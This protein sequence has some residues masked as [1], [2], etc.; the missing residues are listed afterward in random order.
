[1]GAPTG[2]PVTITLQ[3][4]TGN[5]SITITTPDENFAAAQE[6]IAVSGTIG[7]GVVGADVNGVAAT[8]TGSTFTVPAVRLAPG[9]N[10]VV[11]HGRNAAGRTATASRRGVYY[12][13]APSISISTPSANTTTGTAK[14]TVSGTY[15]NLDPATIAVGTTSA[16]FVRA[17]DTTG[18]FTVVDVP[19]TSG[20][21]TLTVN[22]RDRL[23]RAASAT[24]V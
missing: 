20:P 15:T 8:I 14:V 21:N 22:G 19:L 17:S 13:E 23:S 5:P 11:A 9:L 6:T 24:V 16:Q 18:S 1:A 10:I 4:V 3:R 7:N 2:T 12:K